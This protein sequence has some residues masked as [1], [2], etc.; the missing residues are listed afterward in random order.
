MSGRTDD[1]AVRAAQKQELGNWK[2][3]DDY[4]EVPEVGQRAL[5]VHWVI[6]EKML[7][8]KKARLVAGEYEEQEVKLRT[9]SST[10]SIEGLRTVLSIIA[11]NNWKCRSID[12]KLRFCNGARLK[13]MYISDQFRRLINLC[14]WIIRCSTFMAR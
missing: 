5:S 11:S 14:L 6:T 1:E 7:Y 9:D 3:N 13:G 4:E 2:S 12:I 10:C 8:D